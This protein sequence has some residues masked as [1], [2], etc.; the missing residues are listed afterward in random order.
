M[1]A[2]ELVHFYYYIQGILVEPVMSGASEIK[3]VDGMANA[4]TDSNSA[5]FISLVEFN[6]NVTNITTGDQIGKMIPKTDRIAAMSKYSTSDRHSFDAL[7][8]RCNKFDMF[9]GLADQ[10]AII[11]PNE[12]IVYSQYKSL[13]EMFCTFVGGVVT[14]CPENQRCIAATTLARVGVANS[15][16]IKMTPLWILTIN[17]STFIPLML[18]MLSVSKVLNFSPSYQRYLS[19]SNP[20]STTTLKEA[21]HL[22][23]LMF[24]R[25]AKDTPAPSRLASGAFALC[26]KSSVYSDGIHYCSTDISVNPPQNIHMVL[27]ATSEAAN[28]GLVLVRTQPITPGRPIVAMITHHKS[29]HRREPFALPSDQLV[30][31]VP[32]H[33]IFMELE[34]Q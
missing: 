13:L 27:E 22:P 18:E 26:L 16:M 17:H 20:S 28:R 8:T 30:I 9:L 25:H 5:K 3:H 23:K 11:S 14:E 6:A 34:E 31:L 4:E 2:E 10:C 24:T 29:N 32:H 1:N 19:L 12:T 21:I 33:T 7:T 15:V